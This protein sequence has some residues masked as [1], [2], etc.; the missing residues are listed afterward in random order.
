MRFGFPWRS[1][2]KTTSTNTSFYK[3][4]PLDRFFPIIQKPKKQLK[5][6]LTM[7]LLSMHR[8]GSCSNATSKIMIS[9]LRCIGDWNCWRSYKKTCPKQERWIIIVMLFSLPFLEP[10]SLSPKP[11]KIFSMFFSQQSKAN[12]IPMS[13]SAPKESAQK[14][15][16][17]TVDWWRLKEIATSCS[18][19]HLWTRSAQL[20]PRFLIRS[21]KCA[22]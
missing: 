21:W 18:L 20:K 4:K 5:D 17:F 10:K 6:P 8:H 2:L 13:P 3:F 14:R 9:F 16:T 7:P 12:S 15:W 11:L 19:K 1:Q 22:Q